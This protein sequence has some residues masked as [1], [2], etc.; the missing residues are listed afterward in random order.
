MAISQMKRISLLF[1]KS[2]LDDV[3]K[4]IQELES[5]QFRD[6]KVQD[7]WSEALEKAVSQEELEKLEKSYDEK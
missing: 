7:N 4:T 1:S 2:S 6:L 3:L 5:V